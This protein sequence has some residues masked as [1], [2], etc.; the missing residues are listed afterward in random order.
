MDDVSI[1][2]L[3][4]I[5]IAGGAAF[6]FLLLRRRHGRS[7]REHLAPSLERYG[8]SLVSSEFP[9]WFKT[10][11]FPRFEIEVGRPQTRVAGV[12]GE[13]DEYRLV[14]AADSGGNQCRLW[15][16]LEFE[17]FR[18]RRVRWRAEPNAKAPD[19]VRTLLEA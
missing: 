11:P 9:G 1:T 19:S 14:T 8:L 15:A 7:H 2:V 13:F 17:A 5:L 4:G 18:L 3:L 12:R 10:G 6:Q 16:L